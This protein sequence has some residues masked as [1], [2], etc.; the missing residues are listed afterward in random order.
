MVKTLISDIDYGI[1]PAGGGMTSSISQVGEVIAPKYIVS[2]GSNKIWY[3]HLDYADFKLSP[4]FNTN[5]PLLGNWCAVLYNGGGT[6][7]LFCL[8]WTSG[9]S[10]R[11]NIYKLNSDDLKEGKF[12]PR[13]TYVR[14]ATFKSTAASIVSIFWYPLL[15]D[16][17]FLIHTQ[18]STLVLDLNSGATS[19]VMTGITTTAQGYTVISASAPKVMYADR[20]S[21]YFSVGSLAVGAGD[22][23]AT[24]GTSENILTGV[25]V[26]D[27]TGFSGIR[28]DTYTTSTVLALRTHGTQV[29]VYTP[30]TV[31]YNPTKYHTEDGTAVTRS[32]LGFES[33]GSVYE[34]ADPAGVYLKLEAFYKETF[35]YPYGSAG[36]GGSN[37]IRVDGYY[38]HT[39]KKF[40][41]FS[42]EYYPSWGDGPSSGT[43]HALETSELNPTYAAFGPGKSLNEA[44]VSSVCT[45]YRKNSENRIFYYSVGRFKERNMSTGNIIDIG[46]SYMSGSPVFAVEEIPR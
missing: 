32:K 45:G 33:D 13:Y 37:H 8:E 36:L 40:Y 42:F 7:Y 27:G 21:P 26:A 31:S 2:T 38:F 25:W 18:Y 10:G 34:G 4:M 14:S 22:S 43:Y 12:N 20:S 11:L 19:H 3:T 15:G 1:Q 9:S 46:G 16:N 41:G 29:P 39:L 30:Y 5:F 44:V 17:V 6:P 23:I 35:F 28:N 24:L